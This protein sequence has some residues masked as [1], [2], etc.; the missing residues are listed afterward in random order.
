MKAAP[1]VARTTQ[2]SRAHSSF[3]WHGNP[4]DLTWLPAT[5]S[6]PGQGTAK[7]TYKK[8]Q[9]SQ[10]HK[11]YHTTPPPK[12]IQTNPGAK[13]VHNIH[14]PRE[15]TI[16]PKDTPLQTV[17][18]SGISSASS[19]WAVQLPAWNEG[20]LL[21]TTAVPGPEESKHLSSAQPHQR[22]R[23]PPATT[24]SCQSPSG[25]T[26]HLSLREFNSSRS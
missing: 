3:R 22:N 20:L 2:Q 5:S 17:P 19:T 18:T 7:T 26:S 1:P 23:P 8:N 14:P 24:N 12:G 13:G 16:N 21:K 10:T 9:K 11:H 15:Q 6:T 4:G 25:S